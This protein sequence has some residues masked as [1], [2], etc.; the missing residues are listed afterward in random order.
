MNRSITL[1]ALLLQDLRSW[2]AMGLPCLADHRRARRATKIYRRR[3]AA[4]RA[5]ACGPAIWE[6]PE[7]DFE[8]I[9]VTITDLHSD[10]GAADQV[11]AAPAPEGKA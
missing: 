3:G 2:P 11:S 4:R 10:T 1:C 6:L 9:E 8:Y 5:G 7:G